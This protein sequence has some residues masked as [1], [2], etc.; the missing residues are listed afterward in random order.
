MLEKGWS[1]SPSVTGV[2]RGRGAR[3]GAHSSSS[4]SS[5]AP[6]AVSIRM[7]VHGTLG[8]GIS[9]TE[10]GAA[11]DTSHAP[12]GPFQILRYHVTKGKLSG[13]EGHTEEFINF[14]GFPRWLYSYK[15]EKRQKKKKTKN[16]HILVYR[17]LTRNKPRSAQ[18][19]E[20]DR[21]KR[22]SQKL[23]NREVCFA[24]WFL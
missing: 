14:M 18:F 7:S 5:D 16:T 4:S 17:R 2:R 3:S 8:S 20:E 19:A 10:F 21:R 1:S 15:R 11:V 24:L 23:R 13:P 6:W 12:I 9:G 22:S